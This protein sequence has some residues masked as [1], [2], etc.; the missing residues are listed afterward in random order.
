MK[1]LKMEKDYWFTSTKYINNRGRKR[2]IAKIFDIEYED[3]LDKYN[4]GGHIHWSSNTAQPRMKFTIPV[5]NTNK[6]GISK[7]IKDFIKKIK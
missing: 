3:D 5:G 7:I 6:P 4:N 1:K 2:S